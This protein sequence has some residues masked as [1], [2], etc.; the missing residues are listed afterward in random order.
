MNHRPPGIT[1]RPPAHAL[2]FA[3]T[4][5]TADA[6][7]TEAA[8]TRLRELQQ[9]ESRSQLDQLTPS[10]NK[11]APPTETGE[12]GFADGYDRDFLTI[13]VGL[14][15]RTFELLGVPA[16]QYPQDLVPIPWE[17]LGGAPDVPDNGDVLVQ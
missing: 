14:G 8:L 10:S 1:N 5:A 16:D 2:V 7:T 15:R 4:L 3:L 11:E 17:T 13:T 12:L 6:G 9:H